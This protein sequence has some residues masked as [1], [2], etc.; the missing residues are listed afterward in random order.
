MAQQF[1]VRMK[2]ILFEYRHHLLI[3]WWCS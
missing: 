2:V 1:Q 3:L